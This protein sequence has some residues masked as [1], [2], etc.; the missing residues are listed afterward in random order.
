MTANELLVGLE[1]CGEQGKKFKERGEMGQGV[2]NDILQGRDVE[3]AKAHWVSH[4]ER[5]LEAA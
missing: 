1:E 5:G 4:Q 2:R 3:G